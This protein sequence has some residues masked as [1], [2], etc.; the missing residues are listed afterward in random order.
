MRN[1]ETTFNDLIWY[2]AELDL[3]PI[4]APSFPDHLRPST[5][6][7]ETPGAHARYEVLLGNVMSLNEAP[8]SEDEGQE[9]QG[10]DDV[11]PEIGLMNWS[12]EML[13]LVS[14]ELEV[15]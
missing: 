8:R 4:A 2:R 10:M 14:P 11:E 13:E 9:I 3:P 6:E 1:L 12:D 15:C 7:E 5:E